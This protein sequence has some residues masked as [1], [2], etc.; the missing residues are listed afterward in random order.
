MD[1]LS[2]IKMRVNNKIPEGR[3]MRCLSEKETY[4]VIYQILQLLEYDANDM[5]NTE[6]EEHLE[7]FSQSLYKSQRDKMISEKLRNYI[8]DSLNCL[9][10]IIIKN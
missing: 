7:K 10:K 5:A 4:E 8:K 3:V 6:M 2:E 9:K 1:T